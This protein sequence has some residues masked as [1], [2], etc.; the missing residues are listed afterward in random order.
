ME[1][2]SA[3]IDSKDEIIKLLRNK[4]G[5]L[6]KSAEEKNPSPTYRSVVGTG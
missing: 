1:D 4:I 2:K 6:E 5:Y 3:I